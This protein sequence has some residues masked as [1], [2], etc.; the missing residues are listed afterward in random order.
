MRHCL[1]RCIYQ[2]GI[3]GRMLEFVKAL[4]CVATVAVQ[5]GG[6]T[7]DP[8][9]LLRGLRQGC[10]FAP[11]LFDIFDNDWLGKPGEPR[12][13]CGVVVPGVPRDKEGLMAGLLFADDLEGN[14]NSLQGMHYLAQLVGNW[15]YD[16]EMI[17]GISKCGVRCVGYG[18]GLMEEADKLHQQIEEDPPKLSGQDI[19][20]VDEYTY[21]GLLIDRT[22][23]PW[24]NG[25]WA[26]LRRRMGVG[27]V[28]AT[29][30]YGSEVW[31][32]NQKRCDPAQA[33]VNKAMR[34]M[35]QC[36]ESDKGVR[37]ADVERA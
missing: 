25:G 20:V 16:W 7:S 30:L 35:V 22:W 3:R 2:L 34:V 24:Q 10:P 27:W 32:M 15:C 33:L 29:I 23:M 11:V 12:Y 5:M 13:G 8:F 4:Y 1:A 21:L 28:G 31:G 26:K 6:Y 9:P 14:G 37:I 18:D 17:I 19:P 36:K